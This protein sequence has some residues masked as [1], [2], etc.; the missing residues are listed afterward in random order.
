MNMYR[1]GN[2]DITRE[3]FYIRLFHSIKFGDILLTMIAK[4]VKKEKE[5]FP[6]K[7]NMKNVSNNI[8]I[9]SLH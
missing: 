7:Q 3:S 4:F 6:F 9:F 1:A 5:S 2:K 8:S